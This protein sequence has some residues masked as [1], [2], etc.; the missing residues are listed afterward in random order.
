M[1]EVLDAPPTGSPATDLKPSPSSNLN[2]PD[3]TPEVPKEAPKAPP[4]R[5]EPK[6]E[7][8]PPETKPEPPKEVPK[9]KELPQQ[10]EK[11]KT[12]REA[13]DMAEARY[14]ELQTKYAEREKQLAELQKVRDDPE[15]KQLAERLEAREKRLAELE[16]TLKYKAYEETSEYQEKYHQPFAAAYNDGRDFV[17]QLEVVERTIPD[18]ETGELK[19]VQ[20]TRAATIKDFDE[21]MSLYYRSPAEASRKANQ[22]FGDMAADVK[23]K[24]M[25][26]HKLLKAQEKAKDDYRTKGSEVEKQRS[27]QTQSQAREEA[28]TWQNEVKSAIEKYPQWFAP[29]EGDEKVNTLLARAADVAM[30]VFDGRAAQLSPTERGKLNAAV[31]NKARAFDRVAYELHNSTKEL[32]ELRTKLEQYEASEP[33]GGDS[34]KGKDTVKEIPQSM[35]AV[36]DSLGPLV[37]PYR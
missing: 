32:K 4:E 24:M 29:K 23:I 28:S 5:P 10:P 27:E 17:S 14:K 36:L 37:K 19:V 20:P 35:D 34:R 33:S 15:K 21:L 13:K 3:A 2:E 26:A 7:V 16:Q 22:L 6:P 8:Q 9:A 12:L 1:P 30:R 25:E 18:K 31:F 11:A